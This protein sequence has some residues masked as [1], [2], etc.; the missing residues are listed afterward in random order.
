MYIRISTILAAGLA[1]ALLGCS[2]APASC[3][4]VCDRRQAMGCGDV[5]C[6]DGCRLL[7]TAAQRTGCTS[8]QG[9]LN[10]CFFANACTYATDCATQLAQLNTC[11]A[12][13]C[14]RNPGDPACAMP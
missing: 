3:E 7:Q 5:T 13:Y 10:D 14:A 11:G 4:A 2:Q 1:V 12:D 8:Q 9:A 6:V